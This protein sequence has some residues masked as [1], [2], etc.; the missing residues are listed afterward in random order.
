MEP[1]TVRADFSPVLPFK[2]HTLSHRNIPGKHNTAV[3]P[4]WVHGKKFLGTLEQYCNTFTRQP[5]YLP[6]FRSSC[7]PVLPGFRVLN[8]HPLYMIYP[9]TIHLPGWNQRGYQIHFFYPGKQ[10]QHGRST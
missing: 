1:V 9:L 5:F 4:A 6:V 7:H 8:V 2:A 10:V 3:T